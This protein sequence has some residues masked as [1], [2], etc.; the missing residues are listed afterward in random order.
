MHNNISGVALVNGRDGSVA[1]GLP[2]VLSEVLHRAAPLP[3]AAHFT[4]LWPGERGRLASYG[5]LL[6]AAER[7]L[8]GLRAQ[9]VQAG[10]PVLLQLPR[11]ED[12]LAA[13]WGCFL[14]GMLPLP[15]PPPPSYDEPNSCLERLRQGLEITGGALILADATLAARLRAARLARNGPPLR[16]VSIDDVGK[17]PRDDAVHGSRPDDPA[18][19][20][21]TSGSTG[22]PQAVVLTHRNLVCTA[23]ASVQVHGLGANDRS[24]NWM[25][26]EHIGALAFHIR[27]VCAGASQVH[28]PT[29]WILEQPGRWLDLLE[30]HQATICWA[31]NFA[32][33]LLNDQAPQIGLGGCNLGSLRILLN[34]S[35]A[36]VPATVRRFLELLEP[37]GLSPRC[38]VPCW[39]MSETAAAVTFNH[40]FSLDGIPEDIACVECGAPLASVSLRI[41]DEE[42]RPVPEGVVGRLQVRGPSVTPGYFRD[43]AATRAAR[44]SDGWWKT[45]DLGLLREGR[46][47]VTGRESNLV[48][49]H[50][51]NYSNQ[52]IEAAVRTVEGVGALP[53]AACAVRSGARQTDELVVFFAA[54]DETG[55][56]LGNKARQIHRAVVTRVG[57]GPRHVIPLRREDFPQT[58]TGKVRYGELIRRLESGEYAGRGC[59]FHASQGLDAVPMSDLE[60]QVARV[61][62]E[63]LQ[64]EDFGPDDDFFALG[65]DSLRA[66][67]VVARLRDALGIPLPV[68]ALFLAPTP[69]GLSAQLRA[70]APACGPQT[71][72][73]IRAERNRELP[74]SFAQQRLWFL[75]QLDPADAA[76]HVSAAVDRSDPSVGAFELTG[77]LNIE[78]LQRSLDALA[79]RHEILRTRFPSLGGR[80][81]QV[82]EDARLSEWSIQDLRE[83]PPAEQD[84][85]V[86][87]AVAVQQQTPFDLVRGPLWRAC[88]VRLE[89][90]RSLFFLTLHHILCDGWSVGNLRRELAACYAAFQAGQ[91]P[92]LPPLPV[93]YA[94]Y[95]IWQRQWLQGSELDRQLSYWRRR[96]EGIQPLQIPADHPR[97]QGAATAGGVARGAAQSIAVPRTVKESLE[98]LSQREGGTLFITLLA[99]FQALWYRYSGKTDVAIGSPIANRCRS[100]LEGLIGLFVNVLVLRTDLRGDPPFR[101]LLSRTRETALDAYAHQDLPFERLVEEF[102]PERC[103]D[104]NPLFRVLLAVHNVPL[105]PLRLPGLTVESR[106]FATTASRFD[107]QWD[108]WTHGEGLQINAFYRCDLYEASTVAGWLRHFR[109]LLDGIA[110]DPDRRLSEFPLLSSAERQKVLRLGQAPGARVPRAAAGEEGG[111][112]WPP[113]S[114]SCQHGGRE[115]DSAVPDRFPQCIHEQ[116]EVQAARSPEAICIS[117]GD[118]HWTYRELNERANRLAWRLR[119]LG[120][121]PENVVATAGERRPETIAGLLGILKAGGAYAPLDPAQPEVR[122]WQI[123]RESRARVL[124]ACR[125]SSVGGWPPGEADVGKDTVLLCLEDVLD[126]ASAAGPD[127][128]APDVRT[129]PENLACLMYTSGTTG[130][131][132]GVAVVHGGVMRLVRGV[133]GVAI[134]PGDVVLQLAPPAFDASTFEIWGALLNGARLVL[135]PPQAL[136]LEELE[137]LLIRQ[138]VSTLW[139]T[140]AQFHLMVRQRPAAL[141]RLRYLLAG[142]DVLPPE[143]VEL[144]F[145]QAVTG[146]LIN[147]Y[148]PTEGTTFTCCQPLAAPV[149]PGRSVPIGRPLAGTYVYVLD[150]DMNLV[151]ENAVGELYLGGSGLARS[152]WRRPAATAERFLPDPF[153]NEPGARL[154]RSGDLV[155]Y[156]FDGALEFVGRNDRQVKVRGNRVEPAE[157]EA[158]LRRH[159]AVRQAAVVC[160]R[161]AAGVRRLVAY[162]VSEER[163]LARPLRAHLRRQLPEWMIP[164]AFVRV[165]QLPLNARGKVDYG[166]L[167]SLDPGQTAAVTERV[168]PRTATERKLADIWSA[169]LGLPSVGI[170]DNFFDLGG[171]SLSAMQMMS[172][173]WDEYLVPLPLR[174]LFE[175]PTVAELTLALTQRLALQS[176]PRLLAATLAVV[177]RFSEEDAEL[178]VEERGRASDG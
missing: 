76:Y 177:E 65:G 81:M 19:L 33:A 85:A 89:D 72:L 118:R 99:A 49:V 172:R 145:R 95:T 78:A 163:D 168:A 167:A 97:G 59:E 91:T 135:A 16:V 123:L 147:G 131:P 102:H 11:H 124:L 39:G 64:R 34:G 7:I 14:G 25:P 98:A 93:Q 101:Q 13:L 45:G 108:I 52:A 113:V 169:V 103:G 165:E 31:P 46:L 87:R 90:E 152:Y 35:E 79:G 67:Q 122:R 54:Q 134:S 128:R 60:R 111:R 105:E 133:P 29:A 24:L 150:A 55:E 132:K 162:V 40:R 20:M 157:I 1:P 159:S 23:T 104:G 138:E 3:G 51:V 77:P 96:L 82:I 75:A 136:S 100:E 142:G 32:F 178:A 6:A 170:H 10:E 56:A 174:C 171:D 153:S 120:V 74:L 139:L 47:T 127:R 161:K 110:A 8:G 58:A 126:P 115:A 21:L 17:G 9:G 146:T 166:Q 143:D 4:Y 18:L 63:V 94:D 106:K 151:P 117:C 125:A 112:G 70:T 109:A 15:V 158:A 80:P 68:R 114:R 176:G 154:Y 140:A 50:G 121:G 137:Q 27:D 22:R 71:P 83:L 12:F 130:G 26:L 173:V 30:Q 42:G 149:E 175:G 160:C 86:Q 119:E 41:V 28:V 148:G 5:E 38:I 141:R 61:C 144:Y 84:R 73:L 43:E 37:H 62:A 36:I 53:V 155:R 116:F 107:V 88:L 44:T 2:S 48:V 92:Q 156:R 164:Q 57:I 66:T 129:G 69:R